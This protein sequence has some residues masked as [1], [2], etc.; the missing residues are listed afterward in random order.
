MYTVCQLKTQSLTHDK[1]FILYILA[2]FNNKI[3]LEQV[4]FWGRY[5]KYILSNI[6]TIGI[7]LDMPKI[8]D[9]A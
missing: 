7:I 3:S 1:I 6:Y 2:G 4:A 5:I 9:L 8:Y